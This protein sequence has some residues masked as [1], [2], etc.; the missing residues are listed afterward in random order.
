M[1]MQPWP[2]VGQAEPGNISHMASPSDAPPDVRATL[3]DLCRVGKTLSKQEERLLH[4]VVEV[5]KH[6]LRG[7]V[8]ELLREAGGETVLYSY[9]ADATPLKVV[10]SEVHASAGSRVVRKGRALEDFLL[11]RG[12]VK[13]TLATG[14]QRI[15]F[16][17]GDVLPLSEGRRSG[18]IFSAAASFFPI[19]RKAGHVGI[20]I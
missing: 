17:F 20:C 9:S 16:L 14:E 2:K 1:N 13:T 12:L 18:N 6:H 5:L 3:L 19:L 11:Q 4:Q 10:S 7:K 8:Q 15:A